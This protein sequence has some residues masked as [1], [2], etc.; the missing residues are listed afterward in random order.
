MNT[1]NDE[2]VDDELGEL[3]D[4]FFAEEAAAAWTWANEPDQEMPLVARRVG[5]SPWWLTAPPG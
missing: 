4:P 5:G 2:R 1:S 3:D